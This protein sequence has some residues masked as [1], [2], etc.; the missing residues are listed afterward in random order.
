VRP[1]TCLECFYQRSLFHPR[2]S[3][4][5]SWVSDPSIR[6]SQ[7]LSVSGLLLLYDFRLS[8]FKAMGRKRG[9][10]L[11]SWWCVLKRQNLSG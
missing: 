10:Q 3:M 8:S 2:S 6:S 11:R 9:H 4:L 7:L 5:S 1:L